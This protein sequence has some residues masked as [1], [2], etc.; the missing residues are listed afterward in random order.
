MA[1]KRVGNKKT[2]NQTSVLAKK[3]HEFAGAWR[4]HIRDELAIH[5]QLLKKK[6]SLNQHVRDTVRIHHKFFAKLK[7][8]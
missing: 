5:N 4:E 6:R 3:F 8:L 1:K 7:K 2:K